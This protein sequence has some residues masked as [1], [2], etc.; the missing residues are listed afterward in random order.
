MNNLIRILGA[1]LTA[2]AA[3]QAAILGYP[4][5]LVSQDTLVLIGAVNTGLAAM[6]A[7]LAKP[8]ES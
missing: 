4:G 7:Y 5:D 2:L 3:A 1:V 6:M 8:S